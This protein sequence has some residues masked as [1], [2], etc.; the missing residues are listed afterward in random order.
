MTDARIQIIAI[1]TSNSISVNARCIL[2]REIDKR[3]A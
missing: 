3:Y 1:A 2:F